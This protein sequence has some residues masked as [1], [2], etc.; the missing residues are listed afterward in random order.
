[1]SVEG[2]ISDGESNPPMDWFRFK[3]VCRL[4]FRKGE[5]F[6][7][8]TSFEDIS[9]ENRFMRFETSLLA[10]TKLLEISENYIALII[11]TIKF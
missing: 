11:K 3:L 9:W 4:Y 10:L 2:G 5:V 8:S 1:M 6:A 7:T